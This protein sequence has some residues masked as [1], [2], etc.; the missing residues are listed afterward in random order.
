MARFDWMQLV[1]LCS[2]IEM[3]T[4]LASWRQRICFRLVLYLDVILLTAVEWQSKS[5][6]KK[7]TE[8]KMKNTIWKIKI[9]ELLK[10]FFEAR[11]IK[12]EPV[13]LMIKWIDFLI[14][15]KATPNQYLHSCNFLVILT[16]TRRIIFTLFDNKYEIIKW[17]YI[18]TSKHLVQCNFYLYI[19]LW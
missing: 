4:F 1:G 6:D 9:Q 2:L 7:T 10:E 19:S 8:I 13:I 16:F 17:Q 5:C 12:H 11:N 3:A 15:L 18:V 14:I